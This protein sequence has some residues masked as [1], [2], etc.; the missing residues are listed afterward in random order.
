[1]KQLS[2]LQSEHKL[3]ATKAI[4]ELDLK[5]KDIEDKR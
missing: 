3:L 2:L 5:E 1:M 4:Q